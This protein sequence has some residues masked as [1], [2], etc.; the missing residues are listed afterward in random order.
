M[1]SIYYRLTTSSFFSRL[2][3]YPTHSSF[4]CQPEVSTRVSSTNLTL[5]AP[6]LNSCFSDSSVPSYLP[7]TANSNSILPVAQAKASISP[8]PSLPPSLSELSHNMHIRPLDRIHRLLGTLF[9]FFLCVREIYF[10]TLLQ[11]GYFSIDPSSR[12]QT[13]ASSNLLFLIGEFWSSRRIFQF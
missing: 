4:N 12:S 8:F 10:L 1:L 6:Q 7:E 2:N 11:F 9:I 3:L 5:S 13:P